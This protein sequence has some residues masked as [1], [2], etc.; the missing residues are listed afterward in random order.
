MIPLS[1]PSLQGNE[2]KYIKE[3]LDTNWVSSSGKFVNRFEEE[4]CRFTGAQYAV[5]TINGTAAL[6]VAL[7]SLDVKAEQEVI[8]PTITFVSPINSV[9]YVHAYPVFMDADDYYNIDV[10]KVD[11]FLKHETHFKNGKT[12]NK[13]TGRIIAAAIVVHVF[14]NA[15][16]LEN[17]IDVLRNH[18]IKVIEDATE[19]LGTVYTKGI[20]RSR[21][22]G[23]IGDIGCYSFNGNKII[24]TGGGGMLVTNEPRLAERARYLTTQA[25]DDK[26]RYIHN[27]VGYNYRLTNIQAALGVAQLEELGAF[28]EVKKRNYYSYQRKLRGIPG[29]H[30]AEVPQ[31]ADSNY[32]FYALRINEKVAGFNSEQAMQ[33]L[34][35]NKV[36][37]R[38]VWYL[39][40]LQKPF[41]DFQSYKIEK[42]YTLHRETI[43]IPCS[44]NL[45]EE[46]LNAVVHFFYDLYAKKSKESIP[47]NQR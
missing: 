17:L 44:I 41:K 18:N 43:N 10:E 3:C 32:W 1:V 30:L 16:D 6:H 34:H 40:H 19:S 36:E 14:G 37:S 42:A 38:P 31:Y 2:W 45:T 25:K 27:E 46:E 47:F 9:R 20:L 11:D 24:T 4:I 12:Y 7:L 39:N 13:K 5:S 29:L 23:T 21:Y 26:S 28:I 33:F 22:S 35:K 15:V 8:V